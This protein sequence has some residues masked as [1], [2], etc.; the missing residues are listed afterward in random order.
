MKKNT[1]DKTGKGWCF[2]QNFYCKVNI[3][4][5]NGKKKIQFLTQ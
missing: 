5:Q 4:S 1:D 3:T 2:K